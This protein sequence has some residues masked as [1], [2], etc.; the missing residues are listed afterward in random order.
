MGMKQRVA[1]W[2]NLA[3]GMLSRGKLACLCVFLFLLPLFLIQGCVHSK[4][5]T[6]EQSPNIN[7]RSVQPDIPLSFFGFEIRRKR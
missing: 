1:A 4:T 5:W 2:W 6:Q 7:P 3:G